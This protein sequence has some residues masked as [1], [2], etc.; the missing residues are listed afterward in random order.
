MANIHPQHASIFAPHLHGDERLIWAGAPGARAIDYR[1]TPYLAFIVVWM[2]LLCVMVGFGH[3]PVGFALLPN[4]I[5]ILFIAIPVLMFSFGATILAFAWRNMT[6]PRHQIYAVTSRRLMWFDRRKPDALQTRLV[7]QLSGV[8]RKGEGRGTLILSGSDAN[9]LA[10]YM[11]PFGAPPPDRFI[12]IADAK[13]V[14]GLV[15]DQ[16]FK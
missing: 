15:L 10:V 13:A 5:G 9:P 7:T 16:M 14:E 6:A 8:Q 2:T 11:Y 4:P 1:F 3:I 12:D